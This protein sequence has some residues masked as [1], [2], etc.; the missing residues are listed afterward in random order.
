MYYW[1]LGAKSDSSFS[2]TFSL[3]FYHLLELIPSRVATCR[4]W[5]RSSLAFWP[6]SRGQFVEK[7]FNHFQL[8]R[9][10]RRR[11]RRFWLWCVATLKGIT[12][13]LSLLATT[14]KLDFTSRLLTTNLF[15]EQYF[16]LF[17]CRGPNWMLQTATDGWHFIMLQGGTMQSYFAWS[18]TLR[19]C[20][21]VF[22]SIFDSTGFVDVA[23]LLVET[24]SATTVKTIEG[25][26]PLWSVHNN[27][28]LKLLMNL[29]FWVQYH[30]ILYLKVKY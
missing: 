11:I 19:Q 24:G 28:S 20:Y 10:G 1:F 5:D 6:Y 22:L 3:P 7:C 4:I 30:T 14:N 26:I 12:E 21:V 27:F 29:L 17:Q 16:N 8:M 23:K 15:S 13:L 2:G 25:K 18:W 9:L